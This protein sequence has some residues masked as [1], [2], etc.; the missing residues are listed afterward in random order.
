M[1]CGAPPL[2]LSQLP[3]LPRKRVRVAS[4][5]ARQPPVVADEDAPP[6]AAEH[7]A[8]DA[9]VASPATPRRCLYDIDEDDPPRALN[10]L[11]AQIIAEMLHDEVLMLHGRSG[12]TPPRLVPTPQRRR[13]CRIAACFASA[14]ESRGE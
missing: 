12:D 3:T 14:Y 11:D 9:A 2:G 10:T 1:H 8:D 5:L 13:L 6:P 4:P 7:P